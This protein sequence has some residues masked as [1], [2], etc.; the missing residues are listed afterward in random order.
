[1]NEQVDLSEYTVNWTDV[2][3][4]EKLPELV[5]TWTETFGQVSRYN[6]FPA[7]LAFFTMLG[8]LTKDF[9]RIPYGYTI[10]DTRIHVCWIQTARSGKSVLNDFLNEIAT[11]T[12]QQIQNRYDVDFN[13][14]DCVDFTDSALV[15][16]YVEIR[17]PDRGEEGAPDTI[18][19]EVKG[20]IEGSGLLLF[21]EFE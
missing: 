4:Q 6:E 1:M 14:F 11:L 16:S 12:W 21:D 3:D 5:N 19:N 2:S 18:W 13:T 8:Q 7:I 9:V 20:H 17:N 15:S 10:E